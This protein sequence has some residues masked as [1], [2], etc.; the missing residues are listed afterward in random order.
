VAV[1]RAATL[2]FR[3][4]NS[5]EDSCYFTN[6]GLSAN[7]AAAFSADGDSPGF[8]L[9]AGESHDALVRF[10]PPAAGA[11]SGAL[12]TYVSDPGNPYQTWAVTGQGDAGCLSIDPNDVDFGTVY[13]ACPPPSV[14]V[15]L[16]NRC[17]A[18]TVLQS[19]CAGRGRAW[20]SPCRGR[21]PSPTRCARAP[22]CS[23]TCSTPP[24]T[25]AWTRCRCT[26]TTARSATSSRCAG[27][28]CRTPGAPT[29]TTR[30]RGSRWTPCSCSTTPGPCPTSRPPSPAT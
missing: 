13:A 20:S 24:R 28:A 3:V 7:T 23:S 14:A 25:T 18:D 22:R 1:G 11:Y 19:W 17:P 26:W 16:S 2:G 4:S 5:G 9:A 21:R 8:V 27:A 30:R 12:E 29:P 10:M 6:L 15:T